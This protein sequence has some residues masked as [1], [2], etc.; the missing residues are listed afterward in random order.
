MSCK[1]GFEEKMAIVSI[2]ILL[3]FLGF[4]TYIQYKIIE[5]KTVIHKMEIIQTSCKQLIEKIPNTDRN[6]SN[7]EKLNF[8]LSL[9]EMLKNDYKQYTNFNAINYI[10]SF[11]KKNQLNQIIKDIK[12]IIKDICILND[13]CFVSIKTLNFIDN[14]SEDMKWMKQMMMIFTTV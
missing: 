13:K 5:F 12:N 3:I 1:F 8:E 7:I 14:L 4:I 10:F 9:L 11:K 6:K 2:T